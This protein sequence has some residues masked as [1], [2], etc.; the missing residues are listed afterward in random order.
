MAPPMAVPDIAQ[1]TVTPILT[2]ST[3]DF[4][5]PTQGLRP[6]PKPKTTSQKPLRG[7]YVPAINVANTINKANEDALIRQIQAVSA[8]E[9]ADESSDSD[10][11]SNNPHPPHRRKQYS[12]E[13]K[14]QV[15]QWIA[16]TSVKQKDG[17]QKPITR[18]QAGKRLGIGDMTLKGW[19]KNVQKIAS[20]KRGSIRGINNP[21]KGKED[22]LELKLYVEFQNARAIGRQIG[23]QWFVRHAKAIY[24]QRYPER[25]QTANS[26]RLIYLNFKFSNGWFQG[27]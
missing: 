1:S 10:S 12:R 8:V 18:Y 20:Q 22:A 27:M 2:Q 25:I 14:L 19:I 17:S 5:R 24:R 13:L 4:S 26:G 9:Y 7:S 16:S 11:D 6:G 3:L 15:V 21:R 23:R